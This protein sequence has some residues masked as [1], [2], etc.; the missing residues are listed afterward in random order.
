[1]KR[2]TFVSSETFTQ[3]EFVAWL[4]RFGSADDHHYELLD[5]H[6][7]Q[8]PPAAW[9]HGESELTIGAEL[10]AWVKQRRVGRVF[11]AS[12]GFE[13]PS[14]DTVQPD[15]AYVSRERWEA[16]SVEAGRFLR[17]VPDLVVEVVSPSSGERDR[18]LK[19]RIYERNGV[20]EYWLVD[21][22]RREAVQHLLGGGGEFDPGRRLGAQDRIASAVLAGFEATVESFFPER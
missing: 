22:L 3:G 12:Q 2:A 21:P 16:T 1:M 17:I 13:L 15:V 20:R 7:V 6:I 11:G 18:V 19:R 8:E 4:K 14:G 9:P 10:Y 5:G